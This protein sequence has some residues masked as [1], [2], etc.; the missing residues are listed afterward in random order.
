MEVILAVPLVFLVMV[1]GGRRDYWQRGFWPSASFGLAISAMV[2][3][4][5]D[6]M[7]LGALMLFWALVNKEIRQSL[8]PRQIAGIALG[9]APLAAYFLI[10]HFVFD[11]WLPVSGMAKQVKFNLTPTERPWWTVYSPNLNNRLNQLPIHLAIVTLPLV[12]KRLSAAQ[13][14]IFPSVMLFPTVYVFVLSCVSDWQLWLWYLYPLRAALCAS[15]VVFCV[16]PATAPIVRSR[17][18]AAA[19]LLLVAGEVAVSKWWTDV[20]PAIHDA[21]VDIAAFARTHP[22]V[23]AMGD[24]SGMVSYLIDQPNIQTEGLVMDRAF[25]ERMRRQEPL[26]DV[27]RDYHVRYY[28]GT[29]WE[30]YTGCFHA[31]E[32]FQAG[33]TSAHMRSTFC[34]QPVAV[35]QYEIYRNIIFDLDKEPPAPKELSSPARP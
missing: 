14:V 5:L 1:V 32:P 35:V 7:L 33:Q 10:N 19:V 34:S 29:A 28:I 23:Y 31:F 12:W 11:T 22:G 25:L 15:I 21:A 4:R 17:A 18:M 13:R 2:L 27:L 3:A 8:T 20:Q 30:P 16:W 26:I 9:L 6:L 24:R